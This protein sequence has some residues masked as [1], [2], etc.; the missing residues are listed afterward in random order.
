MQCA[1]VASALRRLVAAHPGMVRLVWKHFPSPYRAAIGETAA[2]Y[3]AAA[4]AQGRFWAL[5]DVAMASHLIPA[6][7]TRSELD[8]L[9]H[10]AQL[11][12]A[13]IRLELDS[14]RA[15]AAVEHDA[16][17]AQR[18]GVPTA[19][20]VAVN[21]IPIAGAPSYELLERLVAAELDAGILE[22][23]RRR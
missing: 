3:A 11:D 5:Y 20:S 18:L 23:L 6:R 9:G 15:R 17:E 19:G 13:R 7:V 12:P 16:D 8:R 4:H 2:E 22:R 10:E 1:E 21:G 14:G